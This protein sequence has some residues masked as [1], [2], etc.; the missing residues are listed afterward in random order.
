MLT[1]RDSEVPANHPFMLAV[2]EQAK[3]GVPVQSIELTPLGVPEVAE[4][5]ADTLHQDTATAT[6]LAEVIQQKTGGN[7]FFMRQFLQALYGAQLISFD[8]ETK[9]FRYDVA[10]VKNAAITENVAELLA[11][12]LAAVARE[13]AR[14]AARR[15]RHRRPVRAAPARE[16]AAAVGGAPRTRACGRRS[17][18]GSS[19][20]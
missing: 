16:R 1:Y 10:A 7:P 6:P 17:R 18:R 20:R 5:V 2:K 13:H 19:R 14:D 8:A 15:R 9:R 11:T 4:F 12:E 3:Q